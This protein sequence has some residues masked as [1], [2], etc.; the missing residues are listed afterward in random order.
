MA[1]DRYTPMFRAVAIITAAFGCIWVWRFG[2]TDYAAQYRPLGVAA[3]AL[4]LFVGVCLWRPAKFAIVLSAV[5]AAFVGICAAAAAPMMHGP[6][7]LAFAGLAITLI[8]YAALAARV[9]FEKRA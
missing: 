3:G 9:V 5:G 7:I 4:T 2:F 6:V 8:V 1:A